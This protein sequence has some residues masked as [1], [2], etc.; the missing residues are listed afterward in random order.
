M[1]LAEDNPAALQLPFVQDIVAEN[2]GDALVTPASTDP[3]QVEFLVEEGDTARSIAARL[4]DEGLLG[5]SRAFVFIAVDREPD[6]RPPE[7]DRSSCA[8]T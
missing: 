7:G 5:D 8:R 3:A 2:L 6:R 4:E 1:T